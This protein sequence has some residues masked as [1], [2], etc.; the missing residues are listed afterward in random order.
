MSKMK[1]LTKL[2]GIGAITLAFL[3]GC[4]KND[5]EDPRYEEA[6]IAKQ[7]GNPKVLVIRLTQCYLADF[8]PEIR[9]YDNDGDRKTVEQYVVFSATP[10]NLTNHDTRTANLLRAGASP[11]Y[12]EKEYATEM[13]KVE[14]D[15]LDNM[16]QQ[17]LANPAFAGEK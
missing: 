13:T 14:A 10:G 2:L 12:G 15:S 16:Y 7:T 4:G 1:T 8:G 5:R 3:A 17:F 11:K 9:F 6:R